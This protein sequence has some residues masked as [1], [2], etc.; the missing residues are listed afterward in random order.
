MKLNYTIVRVFT[1]RGI[2]FCSATLA[3]SCDTHHDK[4]LCKSLH[5]IS[6][7]LHVKGCSQVNKARKAVIS[8]QLT[9]GGT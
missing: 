7:D 6:T 2:C 3:T 9:Q 5:D 1:H 4:S 8:L